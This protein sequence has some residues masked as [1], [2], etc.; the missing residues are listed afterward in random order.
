MEFSKSAE[1]LEQR[2]AEALD[3]KQSLLSKQEILLQKYNMLQR[4]IDNYSA[5]F[6]TFEDSDDK[7]LSKNN[8]IIIGNANTRMSILE[9][10]KINLNNI[11]I[12]NGYIFPIG[13]RAKRKYLK[14]ND[15]IKKTSDGKIFYFCKVTDKWIIE[16]TC[17]K[18]YND[19]E[20]FKND[21]A[22]FDI[23]TPEDFFGLTHPSVVAMIEGM[24]EVDKVDGYARHYDKK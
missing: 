4:D 22:S 9:I 1:T 7:T 18:E 20:G 16:C 24:A 23:S 3:K 21:F 14:H 5:M 10:G 6:L 12:N 13:F 11:L 19:F 15:C 17:G 2:L 8:P